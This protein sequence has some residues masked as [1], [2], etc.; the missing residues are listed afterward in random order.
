MT[1][2]GE[3]L[4]HRPGSRVGGSGSAVVNDRDLHRDSP[5]GCRSVVLVLALAGRA[6]AAGVAVA[7]AFL[8]R[9]LAARLL[10]CA[11]RAAAAGALLMVLGAGALGLGCGGRG[12]CSEREG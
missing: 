8:E 2:G 6:G 9:A 7:R 11:L 3:R 1:T 12:I 4:G 5:Q 10:A